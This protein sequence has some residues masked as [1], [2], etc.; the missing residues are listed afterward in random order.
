MSL[1][2]GA[3]VF[4]LLTP[5]CVPSP[6]DA[7]VVVV[8]IDDDLDGFG[9]G[10]D[11]DDSSPSVHPDAIEVCNDGFDNDCDGTDNGCSWT[12]EVD[13]GDGRTVAIRGESEGGQVGWSVASVGDLDGDGQ[14]DFALGAY[15]DSANGQ[16]AGAVY[17]FTSEIADGASVRDADAVLR[18]SAALDYAGWT[19]GSAGDLDADGYGDLFVSAHGD[20]E[21]A[22]GAGAVFVFFGPVRGEKTLDEAD[23]VLR[24]TASADSAGLGAAGVGDVNGDGFDDFAVGAYGDDGAGEDA[25]AVHVFFGPV[26]QDLGMTDADVRIEGVADRQWVGASVASAGDV[27]RDGVADLAIGAVGDSTNGVGAGAVFLFLGPLQGDATVEQADATI[28]GAAAGDRLGTSVASAGDLDRDGRSDLIL[29]APLADGEGGE[30]AGAAYVFLGPI[31]GT[32]SALDATGRIE[33]GAPGDLA[34]SAVAT[35]GDVDGDGFSDIVVGSPQDGRAG[36][37]AGSAT[38]FFGPYAGVHSAYDADVTFLGAGPG[39]RAG[40]AV[41]GAGDLDGDGIDELLVGAHGA[42]D[43][44]GAAY[45]AVGAGY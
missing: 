12:G 5:A 18:G 7:D 35:A 9:P 4:A 33:G 27:N 36:I 26:R 1:L 41:A 21:A 40:A 45:L 42:L 39:E 24:G 23:V 30:D 25:G 22:S 43:G 29:G 19:I 17:V 3:L 28:L 6:P 37:D 32:F 34:G 15:S 31:E 11:C 13:L 38:L 8:A 16:M 14:D 20:D 44:A 10:V 2:R